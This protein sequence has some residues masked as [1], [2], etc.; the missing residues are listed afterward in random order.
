MATVTW[1][2]FYIILVVSLHRHKCCLNYPIGQLSRFLFP[3]DRRQVPSLLC[4]NHFLFTYSPSL[5]QPFENVCYIMITTD[6]G[7]PSIPWSVEFALDVNDDH[8]D[9]FSCWWLEELTERF[10]TATYKCVS[11]F[12]Q[13]FFGTF[14]DKV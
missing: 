3:L 4:N 7:S 1:R 9:L 8:G 5:S 6:H 11:L 14:L 13:I 10:T 12:W 2:A